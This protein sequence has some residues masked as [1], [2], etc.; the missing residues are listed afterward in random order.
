MIAGA[1]LQLIYARVLVGDSEQL[2][3]LLPTIMYMVLVAPHG[4]ADAAMRAGLLSAELA[5]D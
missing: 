1:I 3:D 4:P 5:R 2:E